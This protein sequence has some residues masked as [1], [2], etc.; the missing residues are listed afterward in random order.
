[1]AAPRFEG[2]KYAMR[3]NGDLYVVG[4]KRFRTPRDAW[5][6]GATMVIELTKAGAS[7]I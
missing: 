7:R 3:K 1:M 4:R 6:W 5:R 2:L